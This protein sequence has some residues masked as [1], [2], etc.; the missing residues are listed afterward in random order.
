MRLLPILILSLVVSGFFPANQAQARPKHLFKI[1]AMAPEGSIWITTFKEFADEVAQKTA[2]EVKFRMY[3]GGIM[4]DDIAMYRKMRAGQ[5]H[6][7]GFTMTGIAAIVP[8][9]RVMSIPFLFHSYEEADAIRKKIT[10][11]WHQTFNKKGMTMLAFTEIG[12]IYPMSTGPI[13]TSGELQKSSNWIPAGDPLATAFLAQLEITPVPLSIPDVH[14]SLQTG[15]IDTI[16]NSLYGSIVM[17]WFHKARYITDSP[18][19]YA[20]GVFLVS[21]KKFAKLK[22]EHAA[23]VRKTAEK[24]FTQLLEATRKT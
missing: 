2:G 12:F 14:S 3:P 6:G 13:S 9:F 20:Y 16:Y 11:L 21:S 4:G 5:L 1:A 18:F 8:D 10:P 15:M 22:P 17:Q 24:H 19:A 23:I 7:G